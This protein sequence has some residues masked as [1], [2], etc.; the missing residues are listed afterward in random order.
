LSNDNLIVLCNSFWDN[1]ADA[2]HKT[3]MA[4][5]SASP[6]LCAALTYSGADLTAASPDETCCVAVGG[7]NDVLHETVDLNLSSS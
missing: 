5:Q 3:V 2:L 4:N 1:E 7:S 6:E